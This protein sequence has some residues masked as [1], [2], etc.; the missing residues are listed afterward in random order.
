ML[1]TFLIGLAAPVVLFLLGLA[2]IALH[3]SRH[4]Y[5]IRGAREYHAAQKGR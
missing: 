4:G 1:T 3:K 5:N 2:L